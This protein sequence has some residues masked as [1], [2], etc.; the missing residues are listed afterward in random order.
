M[1]HTAHGKVSANSSLGITLLVQNPIYPENCKKKNITVNFTHLFKY[2]LK[3]RGNQLKMRMMLT[4]HK[5]IFLAF[6]VTMKE[7]LSSGG[8]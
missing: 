1:V 3:K 5:V 7:K 2:I 4:K 6:E 8:V